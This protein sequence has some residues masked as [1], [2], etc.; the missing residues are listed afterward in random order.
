MGGSTAKAGGDPRERSERGAESA[1]AA[2]NISKSF[3]SVQV[4]RG[5]SFD[6]REGEVHVLAGENGAGKSTLVKILSGALGG[7]TGEILTSG[8]A[9]RFRGP[10]DAVEAGI[11]VIYQELS[12][13]GSMSVADNLFLGGHHE[14]SLFGLARRPD[15]AASAARILS[16][17]ELDIDPQRPVDDYPISV[18]Q[19]IEIARALGA[20][21]RV[22]IFDEP[23]SALDENDARALLD[24]IRALR[25]QGAA[26]LYISHRMEEIYA[27][28]DR[29]TVLRD[30]AVVGTARPS[31][32]PREKLVAWMLGGELA[33]VGESRS[34]SKSALSARREL[35]RG[36]AR[37]S[38]EGLSVA[39]PDGEGRLDVEGASF[40][41]EPG[42]ILG[43]MG[44][45]GS[46]ASQL[47][48]GLFGSYGRPLAGKVELDGA[49]IPI[50][51]PSA[52]L[53]RG[54]ALL[55]NDRRSAG[56][57]PELSVIEN[58]TLASLARFSPW[59]VL[60]KARE[61]EAARSITGLLRLRAPSL[62][63]PASS[64]S[65]GNQQKVYLGRILLTEPKV[66]LLDEPT[67]GV[68]VG[69]KADIYELIRA[70]AQK[71]AG[72][73]IATSEIEELLALCG[74][75]LVM[76]RGRIVQG[77][78]GPEASRERVLHAAMGGLVEE[79]S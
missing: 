10:S 27:L 4:L 37:L 49:P 8:E 71:G 78:W 9:A 2:R 29:I 32:L 36:E 76:H 62:D 5:V 58:A 42:E 67:R 12:L 52:S 77:A 50:E 35:S 22:L 34:E 7:Y 33:R 70:M 57:I 30:G 65:G 6:L 16:A 46:G 59:G 44:L 69:A 68:D 3:G 18:R 54:L 55:A 23:T 66:L 51:R 60:R 39:P 17:V 20:G 75:I 74:R 21:A 64:L 45:R 1:L 15:E 61:R 41:L 72:V 28:A 79:A 25:A 43:I 31:E 26:V 24:R 19:L 11:A 53:R 56:L 14:K 48:H 40:S 13:V 47:L 38:V 63:A 73:L